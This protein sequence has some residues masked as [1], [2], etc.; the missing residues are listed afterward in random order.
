MLL[1]IVCRQRAGA[2]YGIQELGRDRRRARLDPQI[3]R[4]RAGATPNADRRG[5]QKHRVCDNAGD[6]NKRGR[7]LGREDLHARPARE[8]VM[9]ILVEHGWNNFQPPFDIRQGPH[10]SSYQH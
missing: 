3:R 6:I 10:A 9:G 8:R 7:H 4:E 5:E 2:T 1:V